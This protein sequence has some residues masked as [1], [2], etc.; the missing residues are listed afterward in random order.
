MP[1]GRE[2]AGGDAGIREASEIIAS[3]ERILVLTGA[4]ISTDSGIPDFRGKEGVWT[5]NPEAEKL[6]TIHHYLASSETRRRSW[7]WRIDSGL[8]DR[9]PNAGHR[10]LVD[11]ERT[12]RL[13][14]LVTQNV[15][16]LHLKAGS[17]PSLVVEVHG[18]VGEAVCVTCRWRGDIEAVLERVRSGDDDPAC[19]KCSGVLKTATIM[20]GENLVKEDL[21]RAFSAAR[22]CDL[23]L[24][25]GTT[26]AVSPINEVV[27]IATV[28]GARIVIVNRDPT[29]FESLADVVIR[30]EISEVLPV[31]LRSIPPSS[32]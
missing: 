31:L 24:T 27:P 6:A 23:L 18:T 16:G 1:E 4:G 10:A 26:L 9:Q 3:S 25:V 13:D 17:D 19:E 29:E 32:H 30:A 21:D 20:F 8:F 5:R 7:Q 22:S 12:G 2:L 28:S 14:L 15:D 11:L